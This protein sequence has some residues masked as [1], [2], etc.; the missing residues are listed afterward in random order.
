M[1]KPNSFLITIS[2]FIFDHLADASIQSDLF[3]WIRL[4]AV[5][6]R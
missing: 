4:Q 2:H 5:A 3:K 1:Y 6:Y